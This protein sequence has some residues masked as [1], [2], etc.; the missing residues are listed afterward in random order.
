MVSIHLLALFFTSR[1]WENSASHMLMCLTIKAHTHNKTKSNEHDEAAAVCLGL[2]I[3]LSDAAP[4]LDEICAPPQ[5]TTAHHTSQRASMANECVGKGG[6]MHLL[7]VLLRVFPV[8]A[9]IHS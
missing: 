4:P 8:L 1:L 3:Y 6:E 9:H 7:A 2:L 5:P